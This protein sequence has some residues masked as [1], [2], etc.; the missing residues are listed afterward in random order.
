MYPD[1]TIRLRIP[2]IQL[3]ILICYPAMAA[4]AIHHRQL[5]LA[6]RISEQPSAAT[7]TSAAVPAMTPMATRWSTVG[8]NPPCNNNH[9]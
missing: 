7:P 9:K 2:T 5:L 1:P 3:G 4:G 8:L 6:Q